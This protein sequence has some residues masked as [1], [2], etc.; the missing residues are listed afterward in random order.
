[1]AFVLISDR[2]IDIDTLSVG[3]FLKVNGDL[4]S[5][6]FKSEVKTRLLLQLFAHT[7]D[8]IVDRDNPYINDVSMTGFICKE[9]TEKVLRDGKHLG[10]CMVAVN[11]TFGKTSYIPV[12][13]WGRNVSYVKNLGVGVEVEIKG[14]LQSR[15]Y[16]SKETGE[17][18]RVQELSISS[19]KEYTEE[20]DIDVDEK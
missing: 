8:T 7:V 16:P 20:E 1:M 5:Y 6:N 14:R 2:L 11:R 10:Y 17:R 18:I 12:L 9:V 3:M 13:L 4:R 19:I 15:E